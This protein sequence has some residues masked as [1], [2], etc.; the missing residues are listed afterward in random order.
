[1]CCWVSQLRATTSLDGRRGGL[2][3]RQRLDRR[4]LHSSGAVPRQPSSSPGPPETAACAGAPTATGD[5]LPGCVSLVGGELVEA[6][7]LAAVWWQ[8]AA[9][10][11]L[12]KTPEIGL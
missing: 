9:A 8:Q 3:A 6:R 10:A 11:M 7:G 4:R 2:G 12:V 1:R 5:D